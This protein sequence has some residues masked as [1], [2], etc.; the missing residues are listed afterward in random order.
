MLISM[1][2]Y[3]TANMRV[4]QWQLDVQIRALNSKFF[5]CSLRLPRFLEPRELE[6]RNLL[7]DVLVRGKV[8]L[9]VQCTP[10]Q[11]NEQSIKSLDTRSFQHWWRTLKQAATQVQATPSDDALLAAVLRIST[12]TP[13]EHTV[14]P[15]LEEFWP[16]VQRL[17]KEAIQACQDMQRN[18]GMKTKILL[19]TE[20]DHLEEGLQKVL[21][22]SP[23]RTENM[24]KKL[25]A[26]AQEALGAVYNEGRLAQEFFFYIE[27][28]D[29]TE[30]QE[31]LKQHIALFKRILIEGRESEAQR[32]LFISQEIGRELNTLGVKSHDASIQQHVVDMKNALNKAKEQLQNIK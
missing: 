9:Q 27:R 13:S 6:V 19:E 31:R 25:R 16:D 5:D 15:P 30:E 14:D 32:L 11:D 23:A 12:F 7:A 10:I 8:S 21:T 17:I 3:G 22:L 28:M 2:G 4:A 18:E 1:T 20:I 24:Q 26:R 29:F